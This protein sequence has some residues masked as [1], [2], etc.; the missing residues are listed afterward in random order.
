MSLIYPQWSAPAGVSACSTTR[1]GGVSAAPWDSFNLGDH[2]GDASDRVQ[3]NRERLVMQAAMPAMPVWLEQVH[4]SRVIELTGEQPSCRRADAAWTCKPGV[5]C[6]VMTA[7][8]LPVLFTSV[9]GKQVAAAH[10]GWR[11]LC[12]GILEAT[13]AAFRCPPEEVIAWLGPA[14]GP[15]AFE[16]GP[17]VRTAFIAQNM[18]DEGAFRPAGEKYYADIWQLA[19]G[20][21]KRMGVRHISGG[22][23]C[24]HSAGEQFFSFRRDGVTGRMASLIWLI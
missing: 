24:T 19:R 3:A 2:V 6:A 22:G 10:A 12:G 18:S 11:G 23:L 5:V 13:V 14:I 17:E 4:G 15:G 20:R 9:S 21:L 1:T 16:V 7:D 8:C